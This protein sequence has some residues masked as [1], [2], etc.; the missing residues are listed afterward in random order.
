MRPP[1]NKFG[2]DLL[3]WA[4]KNKHISQSEQAYILGISLE[5]Y[6]RRI[7][8]AGKPKGVS[9]FKPTKNP[10]PSIPPDG[11]YRDPEWLSRVYAN[12]SKADIA[13]NF[14][15]SRKTIENYLKKHNIKKPVQPVSPYNNR[16]W[17]FYYYWVKKLNVARLAKRAGVAYG[18]IMNWL[19]KHRVPIRHL[20]ISKHQKY[21]E[22][23]IT[24]FRQIK[25]CQWLS[26]IWHDPNY[27]MLYANLRRRYF[28]TL[29][30]VNKLTTGLQITNWQ[31]PSVEDWDRIWVPYKEHDLLNDK[32]NPTYL[33][34]SMRF[35][36]HPL[37]RI[38]ARMQFYDTFKAQNGRYDFDKSDLLADL[39]RCYDMKRSLINR[40]DRWYFHGMHGNNKQRGRYIAL[41][42]WGLSE[43][44]DKWRSMP[45]FLRW[46]PHRYFDK[47]QTATTFDMLNQVCHYRRN[48]R[49]PDLLP[50]PAL[51]RFI[52]E[53]IK[54]TTV[55]DLWPNKGLNAVS[56]H[57]ANVHYHSRVINADN[58]KR[59][60]DIGIYAYKEDPYR[61]YDLLFCLSRSYKIKPW[62]IEGFFNRAEK[63]LILVKRYRLEDT[64]NLYRHERVFTIVN[65]YQTRKAPFYLLLLNRKDTLASLQ[66]AVEAWPSE[67]PPRQ[68]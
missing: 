10:L 23:Y 39:E 57:M 47:L 37:H 53:E 65:R 36:A 25:N 17:L 34:S 6:R 15:V 2:K 13:A 55:L 38:A 35:D 29:H 58:I 59:L 41:H 45:S 42:C 48:V 27:I 64:I 68:S 14:G 44:V 8:T 5:A 51:L 18:T 31:K 30:F 26:I 19:T 63:V 52:L 32:T 11:H 28:V 22:H 60:K 56:A 49:F 54:P 1:V 3:E 66:G 33:K 40:N 16:Q 20:G 62:M 9:N 46:A 50:D 24:T 12:S 61:T 43:Y 67:F 7:R 4:Q 21:H